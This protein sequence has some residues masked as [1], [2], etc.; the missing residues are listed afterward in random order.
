M[1]RYFIP[2]QGFLIIEFLQGFL[3]AVFLLGAVNSEVSSW[4]F[5]FCLCGKRGGQEEGTNSN[6]VA[7][8]LPFNTPLNISADPKISNFFCTLTLNVS[9]LISHSLFVIL[10]HIIII[11]ISQPPPLIRV[12]ERHAISLS[13]IL[14]WTSIFLVIISS[15]WRENGLYFPPWDIMHIQVSLCH[16]CAVDRVINSASPG[17]FY[18]WNR[19]AFVMLNEF[20]GI[21]NCSEGGCLTCAGSWIAVNSEQS[22]LET[23]FLGIP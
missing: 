13:F 12:F 2:S 9:Y 3:K 14:R 10:E 16:L 20:P 6:A 18:I 15:N 7:E 19:E 4:G 11:L 1:C 22:L 23:C 8:R 21:S 5:Q 17:T